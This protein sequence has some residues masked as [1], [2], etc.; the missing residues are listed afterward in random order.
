MPR[1]VEGLHPG[2]HVVVV[3]GGPAGLTAAYLLSKKG[4]RTTVY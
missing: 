1:D 4:Y 2:D 3:G